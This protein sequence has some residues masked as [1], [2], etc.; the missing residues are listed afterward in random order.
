MLRRPSFNSLWLKQF[1]ENGPAGARKKPARIS[2]LGQ[3]LAR[4][5]SSAAPSHIWNRQPARGFHSSDRARFPP[6]FERAPSAAA[7]V[8]IQQR[9]AVAFLSIQVT[10]ALSPPRGAIQN[11]TGCSRATIAK[12]AKRDRPAA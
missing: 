12:I 5:M 1:H 10:T 11:L 4:T 9:G 6:G 3:P 8:Q 7:P 2:Q